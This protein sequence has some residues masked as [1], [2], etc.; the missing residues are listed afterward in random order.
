M[1]IEYP[2]KSSKVIGIILI[3]IGVALG[4]FWFL[5]PYLYPEPIITSSTNWCTTQTV[6]TPI[7]NSWF[8][9]LPSTSIVCVVIGTLVYFLNPFMSEEKT[10][11]GTKVCP[12]CGRKL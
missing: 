9:L 7:Y 2:H 3:L 11:N 6:I 8:I 10:E 5:Y 4:V 12:C 1:T